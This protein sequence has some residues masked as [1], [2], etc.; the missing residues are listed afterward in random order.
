[1]LAF[2]ATTIGVNSLPYRPC[3]KRL[4]KN[5]NTTQHNKTNIKQKQNKA[6]QQN[7]KNKNKNAKVEEGVPD[8]VI[9]HQ[10]SSSISPE[11]QNG[12]G[13]QHIPTRTRISSLV[14]RWR[15]REP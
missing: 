4:G 5:K 6:K 14:I 11:A 1:M 3:R 7:N 13:I 2:I 8:V 15:L 10:R 9:Q 12:D